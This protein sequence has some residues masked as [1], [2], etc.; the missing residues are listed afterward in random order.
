[1]NGQLTNKIKITRLV[2]QGCPIS[3]LL[4]VL[5]GEGLLE[6]IRNNPNIKGYNLP[7]GEYQKVAAYADDITLIITKPKDIQEF[8]K[9]IDKFCEALGAKINQKKT[10]AHKTWTLD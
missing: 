4:F 6:A 1:M 9:E 7:N 8:L 10:E 2:R 3:M 5:G